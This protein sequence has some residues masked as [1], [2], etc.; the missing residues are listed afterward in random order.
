[1]K[2]LIFVPNCNQGGTERVA[3]RITEM[4]LD[5]KIESCIVTLCSNHLPYKYEGK[6]YHLETS[7]NKFSR[8]LSSYKKLKDNSY[9]K[10]GRIPKYLKCTYG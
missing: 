8:F 5:E 6:H 7:G 2:I 9:N 3:I 4:F 1:M 10:Y